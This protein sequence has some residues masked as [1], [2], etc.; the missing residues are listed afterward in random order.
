MVAS[1]A[2]CALMLLL[3]HWHSTWGAKLAV[4]A[5]FG[6]MIGGGV[7]LGWQDLGPRFELLQQ[8][9]EGRE[10]LFLTGWRMAA[11]EPLFG[12]GPGTFG[13]LFP[14]FRPPLANY[15][16]AQ[17]HNDWLETL[18]TFGWAGSCLLVAGLL[19]V[20]VRWFFR[21]RIYA[22]KH[23]LML[24]WISLGGC[25]IHACYDFPFQIHSI[26]VLFVLLC[27]MLSCLSRRA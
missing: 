20:L 11:A 18:I 13:S 22:E 2:L 17:L 23:F 10:G 6:G 12:T 14:L 24:V 8:G 19:L 16:V 27:S 9:F 7:L 5:L 25:L 21:G 26:L 15:S 3:A 1:A 4:F